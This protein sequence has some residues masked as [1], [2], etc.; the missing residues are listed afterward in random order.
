MMENLTQDLRLLSSTYTNV[1]GTLYG[2]KRVGN[3]ITDE[4]S[5]IFLVN[6]KKKISDLESDQ[7]IPSTIEIGGLILKTD[8]VEGKL[9]LCQS[10]QDPI[11]TN[12]GQFCP[13]PWNSWTASTPTNQNRI[14]PIQGGIRIQNTLFGGWGTMGL[15]CVDNDTNSVVGLTNSHVICG[16]GLNTI[17]K[18]ANWIFWS[19][20]NNNIF[21]PVNSGD[22][23]LG[24]LLG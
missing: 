22:D 18:C 21:Q 2:Y 14:R 13:S 11:I 4:H 9:Q 12:N 24:N 3:K 16:D 8:V 1:F 6:E 7:I 15:V 17:Y 23:F 5:V 10:N 20:V 19:M